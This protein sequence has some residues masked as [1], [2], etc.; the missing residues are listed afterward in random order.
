METADVFLDGRHQ[1]AGIYDRSAMMPGAR[2]TGP[3]IIRQSDCTTCIIS[4][5]AAEVDGH[6][7]LIIER[8]A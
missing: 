8:K 1:Q 6:G 2:V 4:G 5:F 7:N 3:A